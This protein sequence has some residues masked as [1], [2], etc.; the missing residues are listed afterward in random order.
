MVD[1]FREKLKDSYRRLLTTIHEETGHKQSKTLLEKVETLPKNNFS[2]I[3]TFYYHHTVKA[4]NGGEKDVPR[5]LS[6][7][8]LAL[9]FVKEKDHNGLFV[10]YEAMPDT[11]SHTVLKTMGSSI[12]N[13][14]ISLRGLPK[15][16]EI[17]A[18]QRLEQSVK[19]LQN[20]CPEMLVS[21]QELVQQIFF[22][23]SDCPGKHHTLALTGVVTQGMIFINAEKNTDW[24]SLLDKY[25]HEAAHAYLFLINQEELLVLNDPKKLYASPV[26]HDMRPMEGVYHAI[27]VLMRL[28]YAFSSI[29]ED[30]DLVASD[31]KDMISLM[32][33]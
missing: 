26:R 27:F 3:L 16:E 1:A 19:Y 18:A 11:I 4:I 13:Y 24:I 21:V 9:S 6:D 22:I 5:L 2:S 8:D 12:T 15:T 17:K 20:N 29:I 32:K 33:T 10:V 7:L 30:S 28:I 25:I 23:G 31:K 14:N